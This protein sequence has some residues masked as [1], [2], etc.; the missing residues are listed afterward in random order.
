MEKE[1]QAQHKEEHVRGSQ[2]LLFE[3]C[4]KIDV[5]RIYKIGYSHK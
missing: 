5:W 3:I 2:Y 1:I 4:V